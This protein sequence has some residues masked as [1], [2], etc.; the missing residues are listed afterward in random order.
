MSISSPGSGIPLVQFTVDVILSLIGRGAG[1]EHEEVR[2][3]FRGHVPQQLVGHGQGLSRARRPDA[4][5]LHRTRGN[6]NHGALQ[7]HTGIYYW[8]W[9]SSQFMGT[10]Y[11]VWRVKLNY[12]QSTHWFLIGQKHIHEERHSHCV[13]SGN[14]DVSIMR[15]RGDYDTLRR[16]HPA[17]PLDLKYRPKDDDKAKVQSDGLD[18]TKHRY[19]FTFLSSFSSSSSKLLIPASSRA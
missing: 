6:M 12:N 5:H 16:F 10:S 8:M 17:D 2:D 3:V 1:W 18:C 19:Q 9:E 7:G 4:Q 11:C 13:R 15:L 14:D